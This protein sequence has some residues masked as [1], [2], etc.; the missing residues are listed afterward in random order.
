MHSHSAA[1]QLHQPMVHW[2]A[3]RTCS[4][5]CLCPLAAPKP[6][7][8]LWWLFFKDMFL[9]KVCRELI[10][11][12]SLNKGKFDSLLFFSPL[13]YQVLLFVADESRFIFLFKAFIGADFRRLLRC[14][15]PTCAAQNLLNPFCGRWNLSVHCSSAF[16]CSIQSHFQQQQEAAEKIN[17]DLPSACVCSTETSRQKRL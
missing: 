9:T 14:P 15:S 2:F 6:N 12:P 5:L 1:E 11:T 16:L 13:H 8:Q 7:P 10:F 17:P 3:Q 4:L